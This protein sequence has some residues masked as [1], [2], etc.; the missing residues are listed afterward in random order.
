MHS[1]FEG[2]PVVL[3][4]V[5]GAIIV[6]FVLSIVNLYY[7][8]RVSRTLLDQQDKATTTT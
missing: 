7:S 8:I 1:L 3:N 5:K 6:F 4:I 2:K